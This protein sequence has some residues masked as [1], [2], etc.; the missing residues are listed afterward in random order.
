M[1]DQPRSWRMMGAD[2]AFTLLLSSLIIIFTAGISW[3]LVSLRV[4]HMALSTSNRIAPADWILV[5]GRQLLGGAVT[6]DYAA[7][8]DRAVALAAAQPAARIMVLGGQTSEGPFTEAEQGRRYLLQRGIAA[9]RIHME[10]ASLHTLENLQNARDDLGEQPGRVL[11]ITSRYHLA[12][13]CTLARGLGFDV[14]PCAAEAQFAWSLRSL[15]RLLLEAAYIHWYWVGRGWAS[16]IRN[17]GS[18][19]RIR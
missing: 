2:G 5:L 15:W 14:R 19:E 3:L 10:S 8:L 12:R 17:Q 11:L 18:L 6:L 7:R 1:G 4:L 13:S 9:D 16:L